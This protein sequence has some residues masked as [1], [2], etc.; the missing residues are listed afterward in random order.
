MAPRKD[1]PPP[2][3]HKDGNKDGPDGAVCKTT[4]V[5]ST[6]ILAASDVLRTFDRFGWS[7][8]SPNLMEP[9]HGGE[10]FCFKTNVVRMRGLCVQIEE[11]V[12]VNT[13]SI[14]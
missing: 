13:C 5:T 11:S 6:L 9:N 4:G 2:P 7:F 14:I 12:D 3:T 8:G 10:L 1:S